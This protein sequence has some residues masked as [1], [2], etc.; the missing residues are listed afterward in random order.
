MA[1]EN[2]ATGE[3]DN[4]TGETKFKR[5]RAPELLTAS[6]RQ[7]VFLQGSPTAYNK[8]VVDEELLSLMLKHLR[9]LTILSRDEELFLIQS[10][11][12]F[13]QEGEMTEWR[14]LYLQYLWNYYHLNMALNE[15][16]EVWTIRWRRAQIEATKK[17]GL[18]VTELETKQ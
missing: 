1:S 15:C 18:D 6:E 13:D 3:G 5:E 17:D 7:K 10:S 2:D 4:M 9:R 14:Y 12:A 8:T 11:K 16:I